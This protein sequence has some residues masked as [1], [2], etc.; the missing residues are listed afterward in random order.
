[1]RQVNHCCLNPRPKLSRPLVQQLHPKQ[2]VVDPNYH[3]N[4]TMRH[5]SSKIRYYDGCM[6]ALQIS[7]ISMTLKLIS[8]FLTI[9]RI[10]M[11]F[12][13]GL[14]QLRAN[15]Y[16]LGIVGDV[17]FF[18]SLSLRVDFP[19]PERPSSTTQSSFSVIDVSHGYSPIIIYITHTYCFYLVASSL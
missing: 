9:F 1:M 15:S 19:A 5:S 8:V 3:H 13:K 18:T 2:S 10:F 14:D 6:F 16:S 7:I 11:D 12:Q 4:P 17:V